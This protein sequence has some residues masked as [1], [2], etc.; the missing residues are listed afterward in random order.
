MMLA[1]LSNRG[2]T[3]SGIN[4]MVP[5]VETPSYANLIDRAHTFSSVAVLDLRN[6]ASQSKP[7]APEVLQFL[8]DHIVD[9]TLEAGIDLVDRKETPL[10][11]KCAIL[12]D[13]LKR[14]QVDSFAGRNP[15]VIEGARSQLA[16][17][18]AAILRDSHDA[19]RRASAHG[20]WWDYLKCRGKRA[21]VRWR[22]LLLKI[23]IVKYERGFGL[24]AE[25]QIR[26][27][28]ALAH[29]L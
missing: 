10:C 14:S 23:A 17:I 19:C 5:P 8:I 16:A 4:P 3:S 27:V 18:Q 6:L 13:I 15:R 29:S 12:I 1:T 9:P 20:S 21:R 28:K 24:K 11:A 22:L 25:V 7:V 2:V 26:N